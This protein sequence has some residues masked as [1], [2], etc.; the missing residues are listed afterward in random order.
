MTLYARGYRRYED[1][2]ASRAVRFGPIF[3][4]GYRGA[5]R[6]KAFRRFLSLFLLILIVYCMLYYLNPKALLGRMTGTDGVGGPT[7]S[8]TLLRTVAMYLGALEWLSPLLVLFVGSGL[9]AEDLRTRA[10]PLYLV[11]PITPTDYWLGKWLIPTG[12]LAAALLAPTLGL[13]GFGILL[14]PSDQVLDFAVN[15]GRLVLGVFAAFA[16]ASAAYGGLVLLVS[17]LTGRRTPALVLGAAAIFVAPVVVALVIGASLRG[18]IDSGVV[19]KGGLVDA[20]RTLALPNDVAAIFHAV[21]GAPLNSHDEQVLPPV[22]HAVA[23]VVAV[24]LLGAFV[25]IRRARTVEVVA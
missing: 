13:V 16:A 12:V 6:T 19:A 7:R 25:V 3:V 22:G 14:E 8:E 4:Q 9:I 1:G 15:Q 20:V 24:L 2:F 23:M 17:T 11:R 5:V 10:L 18:R 21:S